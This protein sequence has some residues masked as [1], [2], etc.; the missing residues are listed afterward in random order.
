M[1]VREFTPEGLQTLHQLLDDMKA[2]HSA[3]LPD[4]FLLADGY[5][6]DAGLEVR[7]KITC[8]NR[9]ELAVWLNQAFDEKPLDPDVGSVGMW[10]WMAM[11]LLDTIAPKRSDGVRPIGARALYVLEPDNW[12]RYYRHLL[13]GPYRVMRAHWDEVHITRAILAGKPNVPGE[14]YEQI[15]SRQEAITSPAL[16]RLTKA[17]YWDDSTQAL[18]RGVGGK[19]AGSSRRLADIL[20]QLDRTWEFSALDDEALLQLVPKR[21]FSKFA[22]A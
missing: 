9:F 20:G 18:K 8:E 21:E 17:L 19:G 16:V 10:T 7:K 13:A 4:G 12:L 15:A 5:S 14:L 11:Y 6:A 22:R 3:D 2:G 1:K